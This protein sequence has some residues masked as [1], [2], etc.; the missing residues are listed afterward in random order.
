[1][2]LLLLPTC[3]RSDPIKATI[4]SVADAAGDRDAKAVIEH[5]SE[6][7][8]DANGGRKEAED[9]LRRYFFGYRSIDVSLHD[10]QTWDNGPTAQARFVASFKGVPKTIGG[11]DQILPSSAKYRFEVWLM[12]E[13]NSW[14]IAAARWTEEPS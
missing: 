13:G 2:V 5:F 6:N 11:L 7:Y 4:Q 14:K 9:T 10:L 1:M 8:A 3:H 12:K